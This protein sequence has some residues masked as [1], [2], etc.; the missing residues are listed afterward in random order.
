M[1]GV[2]AVVVG[3]DGGVEAGFERGDDGGLVGRLAGW[4]VV[5]VVQF[6]GREVDVAAS[7]VGEVGGDGAAVRAFEP[8]DR[9]LRPN[10]DPG[11]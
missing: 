6:G 11:A 5:V 4:A 7:V 2:A 1:A 9:Q 3:W 8:I 10:D